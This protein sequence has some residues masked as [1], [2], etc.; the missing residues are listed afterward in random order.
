MLLLLYDRLY[1]KFSKNDHINLALSIL[2][3]NLS[4]V[5]INYGNS[6]VFKIYV[7]P[8]NSQNISNF[9]TP[10]DE[11][12]SLFDHDDKYPSLNRLFFQVIPWRP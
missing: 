3:L 5:P 7:N 6:M 4:A 1:H 10:T 8:I 9:A 12:K 11:E 2:S